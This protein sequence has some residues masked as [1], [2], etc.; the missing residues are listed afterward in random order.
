[1]IKTEIT[2]EEGKQELFVIR[3]FAAPIQKV[4]RAFTDP[5]I[6]EKWF[7]PDDRRL[8]I[9]HFTPTAGG[10]YTFQLHNPEQGFKGVFHEVVLQ[11]KI[12]RTSEFFGLPFKLDPLLEIIR[13]EAVND[14]ETKVTIQMLCPSVAYRNGMLEA[15]MQSTFDQTHQKL[16]V[17]LGEM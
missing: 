13:F 9:T 6:L 2:A 7:M 10:S 3:H 12:S 14:A 8:E 4:F 5:N 16:D 17:V 15:N 1:M 11:E